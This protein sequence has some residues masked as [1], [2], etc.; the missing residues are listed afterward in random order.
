MV[1]ARAGG[2]PD[3][4]EDGVNGVLVPP[5]DAAALS[6]AA[7]RVLSDRSLAERLGEGARHTADTWL[8]STR[9]STRAASAS[10]SNGGLRA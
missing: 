4:V 3:I 6:D 9:R 1:G 10:S 7:V 8:A 5:E 2:I